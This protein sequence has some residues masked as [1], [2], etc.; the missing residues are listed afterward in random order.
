MLDHQKSFESAIV[1]AE[2]IVKDAFPI[3]GKQHTV[4]ASNFRWQGVGSST[5]YDITAQ[6]K[7]KLE[8]KSLLATLL[9]DVEVVDIETQ[10]SFRTRRR[11]ERM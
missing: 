10:A 3:V 2:K 11:I 4:Q 9:A 1:L 7:A 5:A 8:D 6:K